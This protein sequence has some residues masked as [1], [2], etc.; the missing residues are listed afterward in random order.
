MIPRFDFTYS[1]RDFILEFQPYI[2]GS[3]PDI[4]QVQ[5]FFGGFPLLFVEK[6]RIGIKLVLQALELKPGSGIGVQPY[7]CSSVLF[8]I[9]EA[10]F[11]AVFID[12]DKNFRL[13]PEDLQAKKS[14]IEALIV[15][16]T[17]GFPDNVEA[18]KLILGN[19]PIV[20]DCA[21]AYLSEVDGKTVGLCGD[22][23]IFSM[24]YGKLFGIGSGGF[25]VS[26]NSNLRLKLGQLAENLTHPAAFNVVF[27]RLRNLILGILYI[28]F[29]YNTVTYPLKKGIIKNKSGFQKYP[30]TES[31]MCPSEIRLLI[32][33]FDDHLMFIR[34][35]RENG[36]LLKSLIDKRFSPLIPLSESNPNF[37]LFPL[38]IKNRDTI[39]TYLAGKGIEAGKHFSN[40]IR[41]VQRFGYVNGA[42]P[43]F[44][45]IAGEVITIPC[46][47]NLTEKQI[48][49]IAESIN[50]FHETN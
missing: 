10:G 27:T 2:K 44:E 32:R 26:G 3:R 28:P 4:T 40:S 9:K 46:H 5:E 22:A 6:A 19:K 13:L 25:I 48:R 16:H 47:Y 11:K 31:L 30:E 18:L 43:N 42:C 35:Q 39:I 37:F 36:R 1:F 33:R 20:E 38:Q 21:Q 12:I 49:F 14:Q 41:W 45:R 23:G 17:F 34:R 7:T 15:T 8:A 50:S 29:V 24:G